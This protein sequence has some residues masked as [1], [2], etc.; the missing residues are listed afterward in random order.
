MSGMMVCLVLDSKLT[1][2]CI[3]VFY[4]FFA[5]FLF[6]EI[7]SEEMYIQMKKLIHNASQQNN[8]TLHDF[9]AGVQSFPP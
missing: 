1:E 4:L 7:H 3:F 8:F 6:Q 5:I 9:D 2:K